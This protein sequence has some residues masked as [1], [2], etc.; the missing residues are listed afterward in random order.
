MLFKHTGI[1]RRIDDIGRIVIPKEI[2]RR[3]RINEGDPIEIGEDNDFIALRKYSVME[4]GDETVQK[5]LSTFS[6]TTSHPV[7]LCSKTHAL[8]SF[9]IPVKTPCYLTMNLCDALRKR[10]Q[11]YFGFEI[12][13]DSDLKVKALAEICIGEELEGALIIPQTNSTSTV[14]AADKVCL[15]LCAK[16]IAELLL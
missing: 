5:I 12:C 14:T 7:I 3:F 1:V 2:R 9:R 13:E 8:N 4:L 15:E 16:T 6:R 11:S 10:D